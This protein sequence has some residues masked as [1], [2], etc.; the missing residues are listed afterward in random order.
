MIFNFSCLGLLSSMFWGSQKWLCSSHILFIW[1]NK[2]RCFSPGA[3]TIYSAEKRQK[4]LL[5]VCVGWWHRLHKMCCLLVT[6]CMGRKGGTKQGDKIC[7]YSAI[8]AQEQ[9]LLDFTPWRAPK[10]MP[11][12]TA[13]FSCM[14]PQTVAIKGPPRWCYSAEEAHE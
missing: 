3:Q 7:I 11:A 12:M 5:C 10:V 14:G 4:I 9:N 2:K 8:E 6:T 1:W 13:T